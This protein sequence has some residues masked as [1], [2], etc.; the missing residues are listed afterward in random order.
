VTF[1]RQ[2]K[3]AAGPGLILGKNATIEKRSVVVRP[4]VLFLVG[5]DRFFWSH[6][7]A[8]ARA[9]LRDGYEVIIVTR[10]NGDAQKIRD[11]GFRLLSWQLIRESYSPLNELRAIRQV[12][13]IYSREEPD[14]VYHVAIKPILYGS[15]AALGRKNIRVINAL[16]GLGYLAASSSWKASFLRLFIWNA[17]RFFLNRPNQRV[18]VENQDD[19]QLLIKRVKVSPEKIRLIPGDGVDLSRF[20]PTPEPT[21]TPVV[22]LASRMLWMKGIREFFEAAKFLQSKGVRARFV[23]AGE[24][25]PS[26]P[27][28]VPRQQLLEWQ[29]SGIVEWWGHQQEM[30]SIFKQ[31][32]VVCLPSHGGEGVP[33]VLT[34]AAASGRPIVTTDVSGCRDIIRHGINGILVPPRNSAALAVA[35]EELLKDPAKRLQ[36]ASRGREIVVNEFS[37]EIIA[38]QTLALYSELLK[39]RSPRVDKSL[40]NSKS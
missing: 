28:S 21:G 37:Q 34:E 15:I 29:S 17:F 22:L 27:T 18:L 20:Q 16:T 33:T 3:L 9:A 2:L 6:R 31:A 14:L 39:S 38:E 10:A 24:T 4:K 11:E 40:P 13:Q 5:E 30:P 32:N 8:V 23:L 26:N 19:K 25:D 12:R 7:L 35:I 1:W 36:M